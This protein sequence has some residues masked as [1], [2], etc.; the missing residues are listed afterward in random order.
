VSRPRVGRV[1]AD[2]TSS[3]ATDDR[4]FVWKRESHEV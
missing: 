3:A 1:A 4:R 2:A